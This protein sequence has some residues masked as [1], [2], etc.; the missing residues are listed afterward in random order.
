MLGVWD[1]EQTDPPA[2][3]CPYGGQTVAGAGPGLV[4][5]AGGSDTQHVVVLGGQ[6]GKL[7]LQISP[8]DPGAKQIQFLEGSKEKLKQYCL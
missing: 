8:V 3:D 4:G 6:R 1:L 7:T 2:C 5:P